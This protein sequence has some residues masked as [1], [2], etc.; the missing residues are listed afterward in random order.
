MRSSL[1]RAGDQQ[2][3][4]KHKGKIAASTTPTMTTAASANDDERPSDGASDAH[5]LVAFSPALPPLV[6]SSTGGGS[7]VR[8]PNYVIATDAVTKRGLRYNNHVCWSVKDARLSEADDSSGFTLGDQA[9][10][11]SGTLRDANVVAGKVICAI[12]SKDGWMVASQHSPGDFHKEH[13]V[14]VPVEHVTAQQPAAEAP[15][16]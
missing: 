8:S 9:A 11:A 3:V 14:Y 10:S 2:I 7:A 6:G 12:D 1:E 4:G 5:S 15:E 16:R 13:I